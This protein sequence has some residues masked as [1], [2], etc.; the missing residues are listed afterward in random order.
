MKRRRRGGRAIR[1]VTMIHPER[2]STVG[3]ESNKYAP[4]R[5]G[6][7]ARISCSFTTSYPSSEVPSN[8][9]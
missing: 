2:A 6:V 3:L 8:K 5:V 4:S 1:E 9:L 7:C